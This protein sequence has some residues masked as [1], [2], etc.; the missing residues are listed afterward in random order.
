MKLASARDA[1]KI[2]AQCMDE[3]APYYD[4]G[5]IVSFV[6]T[7]PSHVRQRG[8]NHTKL[9]AQEFARLRGLEYRELLSRC[10]NSKQVGKSRQQ[11]LSQLKGVFSTN[12]AVDSEK[13]FLLIDDVTTTGATL[14]EATKTLKKSG[15]KNIE[16]L[17]FAQTI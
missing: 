4:D 3:N 12:N 15:F 14:T 10:D 8:F 6:P 16:A 11:R 5:V 2:I 1:T 9:I 13:S 17:V 7:V